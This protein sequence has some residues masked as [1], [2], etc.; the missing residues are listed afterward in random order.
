MVAVVDL[1]ELGAGI[2]NSCRN[3]HLLEKRDAQNLQESVEADVEGKP[4]PDDGHEDVDR[5]GDLDLG[6]HSVLTGAIER[7][8]PK[9]LFDPLGEEF[10]LPA[11]LVEVRGAHHAWP[12]PR[13]DPRASRWRN[14]R[15]ATCGIE[16]ESRASYA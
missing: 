10:D 3:G 2:E 9:M 12:S 7:L 16:A 6:L 15:D 4:L 8:D 5:E 1:V 11:R 13:C 14:R